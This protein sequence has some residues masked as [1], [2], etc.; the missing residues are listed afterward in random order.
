MPKSA[1][2][3]IIVIGGSSGGLEAL[4]TLLRKFA[5]DLPAAVFVVLHIG[6]RSHFHPFWPETALPV[7]SRVRRAF[8]TWQD[9]CRRAGI[10]SPA[11]RRPYAAAARAA[12]KP[13]PAGDRSAFPLGR[14]VVRRSASSGWCCPARCPTAPPD[15]APSSGVAGWPSSRIPPMPWCPDMPRSALRHVDVDHV[16]RAEDMAAAAG[17]AWS[18]SRPDRRPKYRSISGSRRRSPPRSWRDMQ[19]DDML[20]TPSRFTCPECHGALWEIDDGSMLRFRCHVG[21]AFTADTVLASQGEEI[22]R[23][24]GDPSA[25]APGARGAGPSHGRARA[26]QR[27]PCAGSAS[28]DPGARL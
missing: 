24:A 12:R 27:A 8:R 17:Q 2:R 28:R 1:T 6:A 3:D 5:G 4:R 26:G 7:A 25:F 21:H 13:G 20:G 22:D 10:P 9:P 18:A 19:V 23:L 14:R 11:A 15:C 16:C